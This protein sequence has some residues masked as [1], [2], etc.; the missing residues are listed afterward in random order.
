MLE[1]C[2]SGDEEKAKET[3]TFLGREDDID[4]LIS[5]K[6]EL[7]DTKSNKNQ[8]SQIITVRSNRKALLITLSLNIL[9][10]MSGVIAVIFFATTIFEL[11]DSSVEPNIATIIIG[12]TQIAAS[13]ITPFFVERSGRKS[14]L[15]FSTA[16][17]CL[18]LVSLFILKIMFFYVFIIS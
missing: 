18:S 17:C 15:L 12:I 14:L 11:A 10:Q 13:S 2:V 8:W 9:Q 16:A 5:L 6:Q 7:S 4:K 1:L 3:L